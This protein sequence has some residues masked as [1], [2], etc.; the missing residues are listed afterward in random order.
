[1]KKK[2][3]PILCLV[4]ATLSLIA[5]LIPTNTFVVAIVDVVSGIVLGVCSIIFGMIGFKENKVLSIIGIIGSFILVCIMFLALL[6]YIMFSKATDCI[7]LGTGYATCQVFG[8]ELDIPTNLL[9][10]D[11]LLEGE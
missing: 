8:E 3:F 6:G 4:F 11:Q 9:R 2:I 1:M 5:L 7:D 10:E